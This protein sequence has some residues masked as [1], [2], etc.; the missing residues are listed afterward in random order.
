MSAQRS[1]ASA[2]AGDASQRSAEALHPMGSAAA[3]RWR[4][5]ARTVDLVRA[6][7][8]PRP[9]PLAALP[10]DLV[11][12]LARSALIVVDMQNDFCSK[13]GFLDMR[14]VDYTL[15][16]RPIGPIAALA[17]AL[18]A[19]GVPVVWL[20]WGVRADL[21][22]ASPALLHAHAPAGVGPGLG[23]TIPGGAPILLEG[24][25]GAQIVDGLVPDPTDVRVTKYRYSGFPDTPLDTILRNLG[26]TTLFFAGVNGD[27]CVMTTLQDAMFLGYDCVMLEDC[28]ATTSPA[29]CLDAAFYNVRLL[30][31]FT[32][33]S[34]AVHAA[35][36]E[37]RHG[38]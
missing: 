37:G 33:T 25:W 14:G 18:R 32:A 22:N 13:G 7:I 29:Y 4:V 1:S 3:N 19:V 11:I 15:D 2:A 8:P 30:F 31:G 12:D 9:V 10:Q 28:V 38:G 5:G 16:Q 35:L 20:N 17:P 26:V 27:Q 6:P 21:L 23:E 36:K 24:G 34:V